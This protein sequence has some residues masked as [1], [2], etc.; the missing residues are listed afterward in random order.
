MKK[1]RPEDRRFSASRVRLGFAL[2]S[3]GVLLMLIEFG[4]FSGAAALA[5]DQNGNQAGRN[6]PQTTGSPAADIKI[7]PEVLADT[8]DGKAAS[9]VI[10]LADQADVS[11][12]Y[13]MTDQDARGW[14]V[15]DTLTQHA[16]RTQASLQAF[17]AAQGASYQS[18]WAA[19]MIVA[20]AGR[21]L[22]ESLAARADV[23]RIDSNRPARWIEDPE[24]ANFS[25]A[26][27]SPTVPG[28]A[29]WDVVNVVAPSVW[30]MGFT[31]TGIVVGDLDTGMRWT[32]N[33]LK[34][35]YRGW[36][37]AVA[38]H[39]YNRHDAIHSGGGSCGSNPQAPCDDDGHGTHTAGTTVGDDGSGNQVGV[40]PGAKCIGRRNM[41][42][43]NGTPATYTERFQV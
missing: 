17:L 6:T 7:A 11:A 2:G 40:A 28:V 12:A 9:V 20:T 15:Y 18:F 42:Q 13:G 14:F 43:G 29:E 1:A 35:K 39:N 34:P 33:I 37:G 23:G 22:I 8:S 38:D 31:G 32:H 5:H 10:F 27:S 25:P 26:P 16:A 19:N 36:N 41:D 30:A 4:V 21:S 24:I 3:A